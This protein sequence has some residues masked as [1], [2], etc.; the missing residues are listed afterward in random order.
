[1]PSTTLTRDEMVA[2]YVAR[3][4]VSLVGNR[5]ALILSDEDQDIAAMLP[6]IEDE[7]LFL[8]ERRHTLFAELWPTDADAESAERGTKTARSRRT[9]PM[10]LR[11]AQA[12]SALP[13]R[14]DTRLLFPSP[15]GG[16]YD[17]CN[18]RRREFNWA[19][20]AAGLA[21][22]ITPYTLRHSGISWALHAGIPAS[23]VA[24]FGGTS[25]TMLETRYH[26]LLSTSA[27]SARS[28]MDEFNR[29]GQDSAT[30][31]EG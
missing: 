18:W 8:D 6:A 5:L 12:L 4:A 7:D 11:A 10:P 31:A 9:V 24:R 3:D 15:Q 22:E 29:L 27:D 20:E 28:K 19:R 16:S 2:E 30:E 21:N 23:D 14:L 13:P 26:H 1:M 25:V 17:A